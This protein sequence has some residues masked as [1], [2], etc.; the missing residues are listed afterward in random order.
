MRVAGGGL[1]AV[2]DPARGAK[3]TSL[4][5]ADGVEWL[6]QAEPGAPVGAAFTDAEMAGWDECAPSIVACTVDGAPVPDHGD[7]WN[8]PFEELPDGTL[9]AHGASLDYRFERRIEPTSDGLR[10]HYSALALS[11]PIP[12][13]WAAHPQFLAPHGT[14]VVV[15]GVVVVE[16]VMVHPR[17]SMPWSDELSTI[18]TVREGG[19]RKVYVLP[20]RA[21]ASAD[22]LRGDG[23][24]L[25]MSW[26]AAA[27][28]L[29]IW[30]DHGAYSREPVIAL[31]PCTGY[32]DSLETALALAR[33]AYLEVG[34]P[35]EWWVDLAVHP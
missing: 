22:L 18:D 2:V 1:T 5:D 32:Y 9:R 23:R 20:E 33:V 7:L 4:V 8:V 29:G 14:R 35:L 17:A 16:D 3:I 19:C 12:F 27:P 13:L 30:F 34:T 31:E 21:V 11:R 26:S 10:L 6:A 25:R 24:T 28:Y 15:P